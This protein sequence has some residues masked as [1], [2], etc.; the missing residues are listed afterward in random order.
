[1]SEPQ[2]ANEA[3]DKILIAE[4]SP[5]QAQRLQYILEKQG[6]KVEHA[7]N[8]RV[9]LDS[10]RRKKPLLVISDVVMPEMDGYGLCLNVKSDANLK[11]IPVILVTTLSDPGDVIRGLECLADSFILKPYD[12]SHLIGH[13]QFVM[14]NRELRQSEH[15]S[16]GVEVH[17][18]GKKHFITADRLQILNLLLSTYDAAIQR[19]KELSG[20]QE[21]LRR[22][23]KNL[24]T[25]N[26][27]LEAFAY[28]VSHDLRTPLRHIDGFIQLLERR[29]SGSLDEQ[30]LRYLSTISDS[31]SR[32]GTLIDDLL[33]FSRMTRVGMSKS[34]TDLRTLVDSVLKEFQL[35]VGQRN[36][37]VEI[38]DLPTIE[39]DSALL[40]QV[41]V[42]LIG[43]A[44][45]FSRTRESPRI[46]VGVERRE[47]DQLV[48]FVRDN[49]VG[50]D[51][52]YSKKLFGVFQRLH[53]Q[54]EFEGTG[55]G[56]A[57]VQRIILRH[58]GEVWAHG[59]V[60]KGAT[61]YFSLP[62][63]RGDE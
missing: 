43:N 26:S 13:V 51:M 63:Q 18:N 54:D 57:N 25:A 37:V 29:A 30:S 34:K 20:V 12:E 11:S 36:V 59:E 16:M 23:N 21:D 48:L 7:P 45:K 53:T 62:T 28:S 27:E 50:F 9:A 46:H 49:G 60:G 41:F 35:E 2:S 10:I 42:N 33:S 19:N 8:G 15:G 1:M 17:F 61:I 55:I 6:Y 22:L 32:M 39:A 4:D 31:A 38:D 40:R 24:E 3:D 5:T 52:E 47:P 58:G 14:L 44:I 56:L